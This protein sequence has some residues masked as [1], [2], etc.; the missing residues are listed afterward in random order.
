MASPNAAWRPWPTCSGPVGLAETNSTST[1]FAG[2]RLATVASPAPSTSRT[3]CCLAAGF[4]RM[5][6]KP[7]PAIST[8]CTHCSNAGFA[9]KA[10]LSSSASSRGLRPSDLASCIAAVLAKSPCAATLG[11]SNTP[12][13]PAP[14]ENDSSVFASAAS[15]SCLT[16]SIGH[17]LVAASKSSFV[18]KCEV[19]ANG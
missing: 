10:A 11:D 1:L 19:A 18:K 4:R 14:G 15:S 13:A 7:G 8:A 9:S 6:R 12:L 16:N 17:P 5:L 3:T 2:G